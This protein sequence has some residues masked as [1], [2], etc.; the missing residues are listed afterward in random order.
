ML[1]LYLQLQDSIS[2]MLTESSDKLSDEP[3]RTGDRRKKTPE[4]QTMQHSLH[5]DSEQK[6]PRRKDTPAIHIPPFIPGVLTE[7]LLQTGDIQEKPSEDGMGSQGHKPDLEPKKPRRKDTPAL[8]VPPFA[9]GVRLLR[10]ERHR[11]ILEDDE[12]EGENIP[13]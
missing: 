12:K 3:I 2:I 8:H 9:S 6:K 5:T 11:V 1:L 4:F 13:V 7:H 10:G